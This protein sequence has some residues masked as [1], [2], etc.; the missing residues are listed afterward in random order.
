MKRAAGLYDNLLKRSLLVYQSQLWRTS[1]DR[2]LNG[3]VKEK[4]ENNIDG[5][6]TE[7][8][9]FFG[10]I[11]NKAQLLGIWF[12][13]VDASRVENDDGSVPSEAE[14][15]NRGIRPWAESISAMQVIDWHVEVEDPIRRG[16]LNYVVI[17]D[18]ITRGKEQFYSG[19]KTVRYRVFTTGTFEVWH[20]SAG[21]TEGGSTTANVD[22][23]PELFS[24]GSH[25]FGEVPLVPFYDQFIEP[26]V[27]ETLMDDVAYA[28]NSI[29]NTESVLDESFYNHGFNILAMFSDKEIAE[30]KLSE[31]RGVSLD[32]E[33]D[34]KY[35][36]PSTAP[37]EFGR[38]RVRDTVERTAD[39]VFARTSRQL[40]TGQVESAEKR[41]IDR[42]EF[43]AM[44]ERKASGF[45]KS[46]TRVWKLLG[47]AWG[48]ADDPVIT[49][50]RNFKVERR[51]AEEWVERTLHGIE[52]LATWYLAEHPEVTSED[53]AWE[54]VIGNLKKNRATSALTGAAEKF[55][56]LAVASGAP[57][58]ADVASID[59]VGDIG[60]ALGGDSSAVG[61]TTPLA[62]DELG[63]ETL[64]GAQVTAI[65]DVVK[66]VA[67]GAIPRDSGIAILR[68][69]FGVPEKLARAMVPEPTPESKKVVQSEKDIDTGNGSDQPPAEA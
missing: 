1:P 42:T 29:W 45:E 31:T 43:F 26:M 57:K 68:F 60:D 38:G 66:E 10:N 51:E 52:S 5:F 12:V 25:G 7:A 27:G 65:V 9:V 6:G 4:G 54:N 37:W 18:E 67:S 58:P 24:S 32:R 2:E 8:D 23:K 61:E 46:E 13:L 35:I 56:G 59:S 3:A 50:N 41:N 16:Q 20:L 64:N 48:Q 49:Y 11:T 44:L 53:D 21:T 62:A 55:M 63:T 19:T 15:Q 40:P 28:A 30:L 47:T 33:D 22:A 39:L 36:F 69:S 17:K 14:V 34:L